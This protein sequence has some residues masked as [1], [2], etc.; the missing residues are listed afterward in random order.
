[1]GRDIGALAGVEGPRLVRARDAAQMLAISERKLWEIT[2][3]RGPIPCVRLDKAVR[4]DI[5]DLRVWV[6]K[7]KSKQRP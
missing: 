1:M 5:D 7:Q 3:P 4:Y 2:S 6:D